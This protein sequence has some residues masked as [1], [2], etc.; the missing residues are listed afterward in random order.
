MKDGLT[1]GDLADRAGVKLETI[2]FYER[3][4]V[5]RRPPRTASGYRVFPCDAIDRIRFVKKAQV[6]GFSLAEIKEL[7]ALNIDPPA[8]GTCD[9]VRQRAQTK[10]K[11]V[12]E[13]M[14]SLQA[15]KDALGQ[16][17]DACRRRKPSGVCPLLA[18]LESLTNDAKRSAKGISHANRKL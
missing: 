8:P 14:R 16:V 2:R 12:E 10:M 7:L 5:L 4:G 17:I 15:M 3:Q 6:L 1:T 13:K 18:S 11:D 9:E